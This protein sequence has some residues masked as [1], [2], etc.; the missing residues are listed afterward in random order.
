MRT[1]K[2]SLVANNAYGNRLGTTFAQRKSHVG[3]PLRTQLSDRA[4][5]P[6]S[7]RLGHDTH[8]RQEPLEP[9]PLA[10]GKPVFRA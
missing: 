7:P 9:E 4:K 10:I 5:G 6:I 1:D 3:S 2:D 8:A